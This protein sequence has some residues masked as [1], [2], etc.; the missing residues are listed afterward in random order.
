MF[1][2]GRILPQSRKA[3]DTVGNLSSSSD[4][5]Q[6]TKLFAGLGTD[7]IRDYHF[8]YTAEIRVHLIDT[9]GFNDGH[10]SE[11]EILTDLVEWMSQ[12]HGELTRLSGI[13]Y[14]HRI[15]VS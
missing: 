15:S 2:A 3:L 7:T 13:L 1:A 5:R 10:R 4:P 14:F 12:S 11:R 6:T 9:P 8:K